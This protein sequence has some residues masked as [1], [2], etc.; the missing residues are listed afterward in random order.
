MLYISFL[1]QQVLPSPL[2]T[3]V[4]LHMSTAQ[5]I[6]TSKFLSKETLSIQANNFH[7]WR[8]LKLQE[9]YI[10]TN[11]HDPRVWIDIESLP[12]WPWAIEHESTLLRSD[13][14]GNGKSDCSTCVPIFVWNS[15]AATPIR[16]QSNWATTPTPSFPRT[17]YIDLVSYPIDLI[18]TTWKYTSRQRPMQ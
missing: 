10:H 5:Y 1:P 7:L 15:I 16:Q 2:M 4:N 17:I 13:T 18:P 8:R 6:I 11:S 9:R 14:W 12:D 3:Q